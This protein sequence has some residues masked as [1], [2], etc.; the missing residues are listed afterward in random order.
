MSII[1]TQAIINSTTHH[2]QGYAQYQVGSKNR[3]KRAGTIYLSKSLLLCFLQTKLW[4]GWVQ[5]LHL[6]NSHLTII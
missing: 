3:L 4:T 5:L 6:L 2:G 1:N